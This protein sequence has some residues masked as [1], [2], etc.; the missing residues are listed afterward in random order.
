M[1]GVGLPPTLLAPPRKALRGCTT[2]RGRGAW[3]ASMKVGQ[4]N[5]L[6]RIGRKPC[7]PADKAVCLGGS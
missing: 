2:K 6:A 5:G 4:I 3:S 7:A 1:V